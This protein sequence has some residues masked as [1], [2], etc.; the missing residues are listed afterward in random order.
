MFLRNRV[1]SISVDRLDTIQIKPAKC[2]LPS[3]N[4]VASIC[5]FT[6]SPNFRKMVSHWPYI[7][8][9]FKRDFLTNP[10]VTGQ[11]VLVSWLGFFFYFEGSETAD[12]I[13]QRNYRNWKDWEFGQPYLVKDI[14]AHGGEEGRKVC[15]QDIK[16]SLPAQTF[17]WDCDNYYRGYPW[18]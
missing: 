10:I 3:A 5:Y 17:P 14:P 16:R 4:W 11:W 15:S 7:K 6:F 18:F 9:I 8:M 1:N 2:F 13:T 12:C